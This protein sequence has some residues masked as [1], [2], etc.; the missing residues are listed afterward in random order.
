MHHFLKDYIRRIISIIVCLSII[1]GFIPISPLP[2]TAAAPGLVEKP[3]VTEPQE[4]I[5]YRTETSKRF[6]NPDGTLT[7]K[8]YIDPI[9]YKDTSGKW[10]DIDSTLVLA[11]N[12]TYHNKANRFDVEL[13][14][15]ANAGFVKFTQDE[16]S[17]S[18]KPSF[19]GASQRRC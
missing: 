3:S 11:P 4:L 7:E 15:T 5:Q 17:L 10:Q 1:C 9:H 19:A 6:L 18:F 8:I 2:A 14:P 13:T 12:G 16:A